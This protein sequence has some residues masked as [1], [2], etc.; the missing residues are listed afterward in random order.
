MVQ[1]LAGVKTFCF[2][3]HAFNGV[4]FNEEPR[5]PVFS[6]ALDLAFGVRGVTQHVL[7][8]GFRSAS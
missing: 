1:M 6:T 5:L 8:L 4:C 2:L 7:A 3:Q